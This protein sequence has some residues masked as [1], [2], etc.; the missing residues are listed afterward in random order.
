MVLFTQ[1]QQAI[2]L[3]LFVFHHPH[4]LPPPPNYFKQLH[5]YEILLNIEPAVTFPFLIF[6]LQKANNWLLRIAEVQL[7]LILF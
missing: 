4:I 6:Y 1:L 5:D 7:S 3:L 2:N